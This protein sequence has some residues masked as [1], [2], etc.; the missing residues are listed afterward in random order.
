MTESFVIENCLKNSADSDAIA[1]Q[2]YA[3][4]RNARNKSRLLRLCMRIFTI[5]SH[6][7]YEDHLFKS[8]K[9]QKLK[10][11]NYETDA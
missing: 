5:E 9:G 10:D 8:K 6:W 4:Q 1:F 2:N 3:L 11:T 7:N